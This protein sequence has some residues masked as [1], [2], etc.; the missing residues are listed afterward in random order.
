MAERLPATDDPT[1]AKLVGDV[2]N[3]VS[4]LFV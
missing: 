1:I 4:S 2:I 3:D